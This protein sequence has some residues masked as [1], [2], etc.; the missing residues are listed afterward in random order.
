MFEE[1]EPAPEEGT[2]WLEEHFV[3]LC[4]TPEAI[5]ALHD[6]AASLD[7]DWEELQ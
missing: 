1:A 3:S 7:I 5:A 4:G 2:P 6:E